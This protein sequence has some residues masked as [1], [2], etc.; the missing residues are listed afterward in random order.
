ME[1]NKKVVLSAFWLLVIFAFYSIIITFLKYPYNFNIQN[2]NK[3]LETVSLNFELKNKI[4]IDNLLVCFN[5]CCTA[6]LSDNF[7][8]VYSYKFNYNDRYFFNFIV[9]NI[10]IA[11]SKEIQNPEIQKI[12]LSVGNKNHYWAKEDISKFKKKNYSIAFEETNENKNYETLILPDI[13]N[14]KG[15]INHFV[16]IFLSLF[17]NWKIFIIPYFWLFVAYLLYVFNKDCFNF[18]I[19][20]KLYLYALI[21]L[22]A[23]GFIIRIQDITYFP[24]WTD[25]LYTKTVALKS[26]K[27][28][29]QDAGN[30]PLFYLLEFIFT[31]IFSNNIFT[32]RFLA[33]FFGVLIIPLSYFLFKNISKNLGLFASFLACI[34]TIFIYYSQEARGYI[35]S[36]FLSILACYILFEYLKT[37]NKKNLILYLITS[38]ALLNANYY[39]I[40]LFFSNL[41]WGVV[42]LVENKNKLKPFLIASFISLLTIIPYIFISFNK[43]ISPDFNSWIPKLSSDIFK[44]II[45]QYFYSE[46]LFIFLCFIVLL[47]LIICFIPKIKV[48]K[49]K[50]NLFI[51]SIYSIVSVLIFAGLISLFIK[52]IIHAKLVMNIYG[53]L[54]IV[55]VAVI[56][57]LAEIEKFNKW[58]FS[59]RAI[60]FVIM[61]GIFFNVTTPLNPR[62]YCTLNDLA[63][64]IKY[65]AP[66]YHS[67]GYNIHAV[68]PDYIE[69]VK[70]YPEAEK[71]DYVKWHIQNSNNGKIQEHFKKEYYIKKDEKAVIF[72][73]TINT[74]FKM[75]VYFDPRIYIYNSNIT[76]SIKLISKGE[77]K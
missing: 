72:A 10:K 33:M 2:L 38:I 27:T 13:N 58:Y 56:S 67:I 31:K 18:K 9:R 17:S 23:I 21:F 16:I 6:P 42:D 30:P 39:L 46:N 34:N 55:E 51:Y 59:I 75:D 71:L 28:V 73:S 20:E 53:L 44:N 25:E 1:R 12:F 40:L 63:D 62:E 47:N 14:Y 15:A 77:N 4:P 41:I 50:E 74:K 8:N 29:F 64:L 43:A 24:L 52:P 32:L 37:P 5:D 19:N 57:L 60:Y 35:L 69:Y 68:I 65:E 7:R 48:N 61:L 54:F 3:T 66:Y 49:E 22:C 26:F 11:Y 70:E 76:P 45:N 36:I